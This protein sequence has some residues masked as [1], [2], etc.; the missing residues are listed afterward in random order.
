MQ[1]TRKALVKIQAQGL[2][3]CHLLLGAIKG[4]GELPGTG[5]DFS[6]EEVSNRWYGI[7]GEDLARWDAGRQRLPSVRRNVFICSDVHWSE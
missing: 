3:G 2:R 4:D 7:S 5:T 6:K 1:K